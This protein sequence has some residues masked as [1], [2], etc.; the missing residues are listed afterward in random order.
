M[1]KTT[2]QRI[3]YYLLV[4]KQ[5][6]TEPCVHCLSFLV[7]VPVLLFNLTISRFPCAFFKNFGVTSLLS[8][9]FFHHYRSKPF[10]LL[11][12]EAIISLY[13]ARV[14]V[15]EIMLRQNFLI[16]SE[17]K[18]GAQQLVAT[19]GKHLDLDGCLGL[20]PFLCLFFSCVRRTITRQF[21]S[22]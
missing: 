17:R 20:T 2:R 18:R 4:I 7:Y 21:L 5:H 11:F 8:R 16:T 19:R 10:S 15:S 1:E 9:T 6:E 22:P 3:V 12:H 13:K 14:Y